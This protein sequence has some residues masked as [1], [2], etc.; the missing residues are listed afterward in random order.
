LSD[1]AYDNTN[2]GVLFKNKDQRPGE[3][4]ADYDGNI[5][6]LCPHCQKVTKSW[7]KGWVRTAKKDATNKFLS[8]VVKPME[9][10]RPQHPASP[11]PK[12]ETFEDDDL[13]F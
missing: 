13:P 2:T 11:P 4:D 8:L 10:P 1:Q 7:L 12:A 6:V 5:E 9:P 3:R